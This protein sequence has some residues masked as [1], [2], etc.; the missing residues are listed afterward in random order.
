MTYLE[1]LLAGFEAEVDAARA[2]LERPKGGQQVTPSGDF[3]RVPPS[4][5]QRLEWWV[6]AMKAAAQ[7][8][9]ETTQRENELEDLTRA[10]EELAALKKSYDEIYVAWQT[11][12]QRRKLKDGDPLLEQ[13]ARLFSWSDKSY[14]HAAM[15]VENAVRN[16]AAERTAD[17][18]MALHEARN[19]LADEQ[20]S[21]CGER[22]GLCECPNGEWWRNA[23]ALLA[24]GTER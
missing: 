1:E 7:R 17:L 14:L 8:D 11:A 10:K 6:R 4:T 2:H 16:I 12:L 22:W 3:I 24:G 9:R 23:G 21:E 19:E 15:H 5:L 13:R 18:A 20:C